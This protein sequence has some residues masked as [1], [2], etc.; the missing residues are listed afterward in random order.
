MHTPVS[1]LKKKKEKEKRNVRCQPFRILDSSK[2]ECPTNWAIGRENNVPRKKKKSLASEN[3]C[4][5]RQSRSAYKRYQRYSRPDC[6]RLFT[7]P[8]CNSGC[9]FN[10]LP[11]LYT[12]LKNGTYYVTGYGVRPSYCFKFTV[13]QML[14]ELCPFENIS[15]LFLFRLTPPKVYI[16]SS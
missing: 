8:S 6:Y 5:R 15:K 13:H 9:V 4:R 7:D 3:C 2:T 12:C 11:S 10:K 16:R 14:A 1:Y